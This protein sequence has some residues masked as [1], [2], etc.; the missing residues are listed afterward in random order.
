MAP[1]VTREESVNT[2]SSE[3]M[4]LNLDLGVGVA[5]PM[6]ISKRRFVKLCPGKLDVILFLFKIDRTLFCRGS[7]KTCP[8]FQFSSRTT[9]VSVAVYN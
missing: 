8:K 4:N 2:K 9:P 3:M 5:S 6:V 1:V 7:K